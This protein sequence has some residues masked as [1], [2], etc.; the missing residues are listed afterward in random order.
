MFRKFSL[1]F[2]LLSAGNSYILAQ[3][4]ELKSISK[5]MVHDWLLTNHTSLGLTSEDVQDAQVTDLFFEKSTGLTHSWVQQYMHGLPIL[6][7]R[8]GIHFNRK[9]QVVHTADNLVHNLSDK[10]RTPSVEVS[11]STLLPA[12]AK[13]SGIAIADEAVLNLADPALPAEYLETGIYYYPCAVALGDNVSSGYNFIIYN[14]KTGD[15]WNIV[16]DAAGNELARANW[17]SHC[18]Q[19]VKKLSRRASGA[20]S[21][22]YNAFHINT[23]SPLYGTRMKLGNPYDTTASPY[24]WHDAN[25]VQGAEYTITRGNNVYASEDA[26]ADN[27]PGFSPSGG[28]SLIFDFSYNPAEPDPMNYQTF[29]I[30]NLFV[31]N[32][33]I[34][35][36]MHHYGFTEEAGN[37]QDFNYTGLGEQS[38]AVNADAQDGS[39]T[40]NANF[41]TPPDG[42]NPRMQMFIW[43]AGSG[44]SL[45]VNKSIPDVY[46]AGRTASG[47]GGNLGV[48]QVTGNMVLVNDG[49]GNDKYKGC[50]SLKNASALKNNIAAIERGNCSFVQKVYKA[51]LAGAIA[52]VILDTAVA[53]R[54]IT[55]ASDNTAQASLITIPAIF[56]KYSDANNLMESLLAGPVNVS[57][58]DSSGFQPRTDSDLDMAVIAHEYTHGISNRLTCGP[59][60]TTALANAEQ[61][62]EGWSDFIALALTVKSGDVGSTPRG[63]GNWLIGE[64]KNGGGIRDYPYTTNMSKNPHTY[65]NIILNSTLGRT[66]VHY[67]GEVWCAMLWD[68]HWSLVEKYGYNKDLYRGTGG[69]NMA[70]RL[71]MQGLILQKCSPGFV[72]GRNAILK[73]DSLLYGAANNKLIWEVF[74]RRG[75]GYSASQGSA[76][77][78][79]DGKEAY[80]LPPGINKVNPL[81]N[82]LQEVR[83]Y[84]N[85]AGNH[86]TIEPANCP[87][88]LSVQIYSADGR[89]VNCKAQKLQGGAWVLGLADIPAGIYFVETELPDKKMTSRIVK[90]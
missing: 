18:T 14:L 77:N 29:A 40:N 24:G 23:E 54:T 88:I 61:M 8:I 70:I 74:A 85:P 41:S 90:K 87:D 56:I 45:R 62:G 2:I 30:T 86:I 57:L 20:E 7:A 49:A 13:Q 38:D 31:V 89:R 63:V 37:F 83:I 16:L 21:S 43:D 84:P 11:P 3:T 71:V 50:N 81:T 78:T 51:Q 72:D 27:L 75:L 58:Y 59:S 80:D 53:D 5:T 15:W 64:D 67:V 66:E 55:M 28:S 1:I 68:L 22:E 17:T 10:W 12:L 82:G 32:N 60:N 44:V 4:A 19:S 79:G 47:W 48:V 33:Q 9:G 65:K 36:V 26:D 34:H 42:S 76:N 69:N 46:T 35:D 25:G 39:G 6:N 73:A 52:A